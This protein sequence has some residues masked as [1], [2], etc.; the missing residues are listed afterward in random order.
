MGAGQSYSVG[1]SSE[2][3][4]R[5][6]YCGNLL[7]RPLC[8]KQASVLLMF[9]FFYIFSDFSQ[10]NNLNIYRTDLHEICRIGRPLSVD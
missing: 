3:A 6:K 5:C 8:A 9:Y 10:T 7:A 2:A 1:S 4:V